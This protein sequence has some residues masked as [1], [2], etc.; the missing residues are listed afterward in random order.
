MYILYIYITQDLYLKSK[1]SVK[2]ENSDSITLLYLLYEKYFFSYS[3][4][5]IEIY[6]KQKKVELAKQHFQ[7]DNCSKLF[8]F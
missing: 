5:T 6:T 7:S 4:Q 3:M 1:Y 8:F 2:M